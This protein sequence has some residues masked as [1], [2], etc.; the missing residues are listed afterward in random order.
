MRSVLSDVKYWFSR[1]EE[2]RTIAEAMQDPE[3]AWIMLGSPRVMIGQQPEPPNAGLG[4]IQSLI[5]TGGA[6]PRWRCKRD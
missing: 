1:A 4:H 5:M 3:A 6:R 2:A